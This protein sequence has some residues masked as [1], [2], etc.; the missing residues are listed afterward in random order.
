MPR[1]GR[2]A[3]SQ[4]L[5]APR[6]R[7]LRRPGPAPLG[8]RAIG[9]SMVTATAPSGAADVRLGTI[10]WRGWAGELPTA[11]DDV[12]TPSASAAMA[13]APVKASFWSELSACCGKP[14]S[15]PANAGNLCGKTAMPQAS[16]CAHENQWRA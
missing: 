2:P 13:V 4:Q 11:F 7:G 3:P 9:M 6:R 5:P 1:T 10:S 16:E 14:G 8:S 15:S 12:A